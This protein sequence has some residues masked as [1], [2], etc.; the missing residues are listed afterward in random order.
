MLNRTISRHPYKRK[1]RHSINIIEIR[2]YFKKFTLLFERGEKRSTDQ[3]PQR[4][5]FTEPTLFIFV[6]AICF[7]S[8]ICEY[9][10]FIVDCSGMI[11]GIMMVV[12]IMVEDS[13]L[14]RHLI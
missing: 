13:F 6:M 5:L 7:C 3:I 9:C 12:V 8:Y 4:T 2:N 14:Y 1:T 10:L 11:V